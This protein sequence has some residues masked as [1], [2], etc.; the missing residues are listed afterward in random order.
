MNKEVSLIIHR[1][2]TIAIWYSEKSCH[3]EEIDPDDTSI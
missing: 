1:R 3:Y 2:Q